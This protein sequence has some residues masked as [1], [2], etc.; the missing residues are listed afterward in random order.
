VYVPDEGG[1]MDLPPLP[2]RPSN[3]SLGSANIDMEVFE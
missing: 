3:D 2:H 1:D